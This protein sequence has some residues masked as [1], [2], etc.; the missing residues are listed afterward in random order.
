MLPKDMC[1]VW[2]LASS[3]ANK[4]AR[5]VERIVCFI[6]DASIQRGRADVCPKANSPSLLTVGEE[7]LL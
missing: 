6:S 4:Q 1:G 5:L 2:L 7:E 3:K